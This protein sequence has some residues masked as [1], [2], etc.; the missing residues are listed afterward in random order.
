V[1]W[2]LSLI[3]KQLKAPVLDTSLSLITPYLAFILAQSFGGS[4]V[5]AVVIAGLFLAYRSPSIQSAE[6]RIAERLNWRT[7]DYLLQNAVF[8][9][10]GLNLV[11]IAQGAFTH[12]PGL[13]QTIGI[14]FGILGALVVSRFVWVMTLTLLY[15]RGPR[16]LRGRSWSWRNGIAVSSAGIRGV[17]TLIAVYLLPEH[18]RGL[19]FLR[20]LALVV[21]VGTLLEGLL[22]PVIIR[23]LK[24]PSPNYDQEHQERFALMS[25]A[26]QAGVDE[27]EAHLTGDDEDEVVERLR[28][29]AA[30]LEEAIALP[31]EDGREPRLAAYTRL[32]KTMIAA[33]RRAVL[34][35]RREGRYQEPAIESVLA[36]IDAEETALKLASPRKKA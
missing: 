25:E 34:Q 5:L 23:A 36:A 24:L 9:F 29:N 32:R 27:L 21:V 35:A 26:E 13:W 8:L 22:L 16:F 10:I 15:R 2:V 30:F 19:E 20:F 1:G 31:K 17:V 11:D 6:A 33:Q 4:G 12:S 7:I 28:M 3:R 18:T 14:C